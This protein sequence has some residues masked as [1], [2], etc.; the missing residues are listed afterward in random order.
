MNIKLVESLAQ[1]I[2]SLSEEERNLLYSQINVTTALSTVPQSIQPEV[3]DLEN[4]LKN[5]EVQYQMSSENFYQRFRSGELGDAMD[6]FEW[7]VFYEMWSAAQNQSQ[8]LE[9]KN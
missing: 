2:L 3:L 6:F 7:S 9:T 5:F 1:V 4:R 8:P